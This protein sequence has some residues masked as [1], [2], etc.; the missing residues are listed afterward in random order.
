MCPGE[1]LFVDVL[2]VQHYRQAV[3]LNANAHEAYFNFGV[4]CY[5]SNRSR[6]AEAAFQKALSLDPGYAEAHNN[7]GALL[8]EQ[9][10][11]AGAEYHFQKAIEFQPGLRLARFHLGRIYATQRKFALA[12]EQFERAASVD[13]EATPAYLYALGATQARAGKAAI[14]RSTLAAARQKALA[15]RQSSLAASIGRDLEKLRR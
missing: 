15:R 2:R 9:G 4:L 1:I 8:Q 10:D 14:A 11:L 5:Q 13:D 7:L 3:A 12:I 6:E